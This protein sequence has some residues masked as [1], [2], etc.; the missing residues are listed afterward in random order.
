MRSTFLALLVM[1]SAAFAEDGFETWKKQ[2]PKEA[3]SFHE[4]DDI[5]W[6]QWYRRG[7]SPAFAWKNTDPKAVHTFARPQLVSER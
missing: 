7:F 4:A 3:R 6:Q 1:M 5:Y 2:L